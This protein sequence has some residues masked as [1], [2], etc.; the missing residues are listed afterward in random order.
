MD[1]GVTSEIAYI[2]K[3]LLT[4][5]YPH[6]ES[7]IRVHLGRTHNMYVPDSRVAQ[8]NNCLRL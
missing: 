3:I 4:G 5:I 6:K 1:L 2:Y 7:N 8:E